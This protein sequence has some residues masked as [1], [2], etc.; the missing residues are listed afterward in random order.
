MS[1][2]DK[3]AESVRARREKQ[4][5]DKIALQ[6]SAAKLIE[7]INSY[8]GI[9]PQLPHA[10]ALARA[11]DQHGTRVNPGDLTDFEENGSLR[12]RLIF[13]VMSYASSLGK[14]VVPAVIKRTEESAKF[15][16]NVNNGG[17]IDFFPNSLEAIEVAPGVWERL[18]AEFDK[19]K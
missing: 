14:I 2:Y 7:A 10:L 19:L 18:T 15:Y 5:M 8:A 17:D 4:G 11:D 13:Q 9:S 16:V 6:H 12:F 3:Y 1:I